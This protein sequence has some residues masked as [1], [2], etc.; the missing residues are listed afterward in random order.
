MKDFNFHTAHLLH[1]VGNMLKEKLGSQGEKAVALALE[2]Y[3]RTF[4][5]EYLDVLEGVDHEQF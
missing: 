5:Q 2:D 3:V 1:T 4:G